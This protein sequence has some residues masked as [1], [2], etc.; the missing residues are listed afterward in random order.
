M[1]T[2]S[3]RKRIEQTRHAR[4]ATALI[5]ATLVMANVV[6]IAGIGVAHAGSFPDVRYYAPLTV[7]R[8]FPA[9]AEVAPAAKV[10]APRPSAAMVTIPPA[11]RAATKPATRKPEAVRNFTEVITTGS[12]AR[13]TSHANSRYLLIALMALALGTMG[14]VSFHMFRNLAREI[15]DGERNRARL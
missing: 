13:A 14:G 7:Q 5:L 8:E 12:I 2:V 1:F 4:K 11:T 3:R 10:E 15:A 9:M 6:A